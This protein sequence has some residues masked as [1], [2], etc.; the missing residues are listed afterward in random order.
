MPN[1]NDF[2]LVPSFNNR[3]KLYIIIYIIKVSVIFLIK[4]TQSELNMRNISF[5]EVKRLPDIYKN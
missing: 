4:L 3:Y 5:D 1:G 2:R